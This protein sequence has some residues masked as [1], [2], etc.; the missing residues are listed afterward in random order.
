MFGTGNIILAGRKSHASACLSSI[1]MSH[2]LSQQCKNSV[3]LWPAAQAAPNSVITG[4][5]ACR[6]SPKIKDDSVNVNCSTKFPGIAISVSAKGVTP[7]LY[8]RRSMIII[9]GITSAS[10]L[11]TV[12][13]DVEKIIAPFALSPEQ[14]DPADGMHSPAPNT[15]SDSAQM[16]VGG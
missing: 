8:L 7:E 10:Q 3:N 9:P 16:P 15:A 2:V 12:V 5:L 11:A 6:I 4:Q 1:R 14:A 13:T